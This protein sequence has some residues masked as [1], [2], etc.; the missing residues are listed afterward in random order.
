VNPGKKVKATAPRE[1]VSAVQLGIEVNPS[2]QGNKIKC[3][4]YLE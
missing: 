3:S 4:V 1:Q 2:H